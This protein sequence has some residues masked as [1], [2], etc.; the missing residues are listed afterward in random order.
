MHDRPNLV[1]IVGTICYH[2]LMLNKYEIT[3]FIFIGMQRINI[4]LE[5]RIKVKIK[6]G[7]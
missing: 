7:I 1:K 4:S 2:N 6:V 5:D 3:F